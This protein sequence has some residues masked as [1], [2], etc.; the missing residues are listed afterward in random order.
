M[1]KLVALT[2]KNIELLEKFLFIA[3]NSLT[4]FRYFNKRPLSVIKNHL[5][6]YIMEVDGL[7][8]CYGHLDRE[9]D[10]V[11]LGIAVA[12]KFNNKGLGMIM[13]KSLLSYAKEAGVK[14]ISLAVD[15]DNRAAL[16][17]Y[18][19]HGFKLKETGP[20]FSIYTLDNA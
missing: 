1:Q 17:L 5:I 7:P 9:N 2:E 19:K 11:W 12:E 20:S 14:S 8:V 18:K 4:T 15:N 3:G 16:K 6:T 10:I 13:M